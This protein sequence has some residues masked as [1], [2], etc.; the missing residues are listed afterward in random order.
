M[1]KKGLIIMAAVLLL[2]GG[3][4]WA[5]DSSGPET[6]LTPED[7]FYDAARAV[8]DAQY[9]LAAD[10]EEKIMIQNE[11]SER[12]LA[13]M[14]NARDSE[15]FDELLET[16]AEHEQEMGEL[17][18]ELDEPDFDRVYELVIKSSEQKLVRLTEML[19]DDELPDEAKEG[20]Q[21]ALDNQKMAMEK[22]QAALKKAEE[23]HDK[24]RSRGNQENGEIPGPPEDIESGPP[25]GKTP[26]LPVDDGQGPPV[27]VNQGPPSDINSGPPGNDIPA[28]GSAPGG[29][30]RP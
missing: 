2:F 10:P 19:E 23:A 16:Y 21:K 4:V 1:L 18:E 28:G 5:L 20:A 8:E 12:R 25:D 26:E 13:A 24:A 9:E 15:D 22:L 30:R 27:D 6:G 3:T 14:E 17:L 11:Y 29:G 7:P